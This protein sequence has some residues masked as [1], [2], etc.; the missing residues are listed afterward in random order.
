MIRLLC[1]NTDGLKHRID[2]IH[3]WPDDTQALIYERFRDHMESQD[4][5]SGNVYYIQRTKE[6]D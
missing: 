5:S 4:H 1:Y 6:Q 2:I 3:E